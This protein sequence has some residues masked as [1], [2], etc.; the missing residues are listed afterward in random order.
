MSRKIFRSSGENS[1]GWFSPSLI[2]FSISLL[3]WGIFAMSPFQEDLQAA[4]FY[5]LEG[6]TG[7][8][9]AGRVKKKVQVLSFDVVTAPMRA[10]S[11]NTGSVSSAPGQWSPRNTYEYVE[12][13]P[14]VF[15]QREGE[16]R[17][18]LLADASKGRFRIDDLEAG[19]YRLTF[20]VPDLGFM[21]KMVV[22]SPEEADQDG[23]VK[24]EF[25]FEP[26]GEAIEPVERGDIS[27]KAARLFEKAVKEFNQGNS[28]KAFKEFENAVKEEDQYAEAWEYMGMIRHSE[29]NLDD[30]E[31][32]FRR[33][34]E[35]DP[36]SYRAL[37][38]LGTILLLKGDPAGA[39]ALYRKA[40]L[41]RPD[42]P[43][44][45][46]QLGMALFQLEKFSEALDQ[47]AKAR[48]IDPEHFSQPQILAAEIFRILG[49]R[50]SVVAELE[51][52]LEHFPD[53]PKVPAIKEVL[54]AVPFQ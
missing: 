5:Q 53:D 51:D 6:R 20:A 45:R 19:E 50:E 46:T 47:L 16:F 4:E 15:L 41:I 38:D 18:C 29:Q 35:I 39:G 44:P 28:K 54:A 30:A 12:M 14:I 27:T 33:S 40:I 25:D 17:H 42:D 2:L 21:E 49:S 34:L 9:H 24:L 48:T 1:S 22:I 13:K 52:F 26:Q 31:K 37:A 32:Y 36:N 3:V 23:K 8:P 7:L 43:Q 11:A 10:G